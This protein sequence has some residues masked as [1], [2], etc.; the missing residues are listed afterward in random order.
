MLGRYTNKQ[1]GRL[2]EID[3]VDIGDTGATFWYADDYDCFKTKELKNH[4]INDIEENKNEINQEKERD[5]V[6]DVYQYLVEQK[7]KHALTN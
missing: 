1:N 3:R 6:G 4:W 5:T 7:T 2:I